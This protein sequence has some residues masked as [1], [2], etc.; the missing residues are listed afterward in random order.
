M[1]NIYTIR[2]DEDRWA[3]SADSEDSAASKAIDWAQVSSDELA[4]TI[5]PGWGESTDWDQEYLYLVSLDG[6]VVLCETAAERA[7]WNRVRLV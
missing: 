3:V 6:S 4:V 5:N 7:E 1:S 2:M